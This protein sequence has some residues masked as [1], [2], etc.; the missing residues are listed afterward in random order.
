MTPFKTLMNRLRTGLLALVTFAAV[1]TTGLVGVAVPTS[2][3]AALSMSTALRT[4]RA[5]AYITQAGAGAKLKLYNG[6]RPAAVGAV[7]GGNTL[8]ATVTFG[9]T[10]GTATAGT[11]DFDEAGATQSSGSHVSGTP[12]FAD[13]TTSADVVVMRIDIGAGAGNWQFTGTVT[14]GVNITLTTLVITEGNAS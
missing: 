5:Q 11:L 10:I 9:S 13:I 12:T 1:A 4:A 2:A 7:T 14:T 3:D 8:L 6:T